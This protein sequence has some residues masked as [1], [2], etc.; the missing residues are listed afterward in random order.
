MS[1]VIGLPNSA[2]WKN[3]SYDLIL[4]IVNQLTKMVHYVSVQITIN[5]PGLA[6]IIINVVASHHRMPESIVID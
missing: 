6:K 4:V 2:Y 5:T 3:D 1:F